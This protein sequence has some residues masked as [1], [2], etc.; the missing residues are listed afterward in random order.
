M[1]EYTDYLI[2]RKRNYL[3]LLLQGIKYKFKKNINKRF[4]YKL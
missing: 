2:N 3:R 4:K 1:F